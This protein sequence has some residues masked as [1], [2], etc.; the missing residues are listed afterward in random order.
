MVLK[1]ETWVAPGPKCSEKSQAS[2]TLLQRH[3]IQLLVRARSYILGDKEQ[4]TQ[5]SGTRHVT[6]PCSPL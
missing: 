4:P 2:L 1:K 5:L 6:P 3:L